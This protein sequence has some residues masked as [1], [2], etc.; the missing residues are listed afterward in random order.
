M[1][2]LSCIGGTLS[3]A[4]YKQFA[5]S[6]NNLPFRKWEQEKWPS[7]LK[8]LWLDFL[9]ICTLGKVLRKT[10]KLMLQLRKVQG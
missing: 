7:V 4:L 5:F 6:I 9:E 8:D 3:L 10:G 2:L 1:F